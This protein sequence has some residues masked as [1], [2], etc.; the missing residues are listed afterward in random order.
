MAVE[1]LTPTPPEN[2]TSADQAM[3]LAGSIATL[4]RNAVGSLR[5]FAE[6]CEARAGAAEKRRADAEAAL[7]GLQV[8]LAAKADLEATLQRLTTD[9]A[10]ATAK[11]DDVKAA[12]AAFQRKMTGLLG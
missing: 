1:N 2:L 5:Q 3:Q 8:K 7:E 9:V 6:E 11:L 12:T 10:S 4:M